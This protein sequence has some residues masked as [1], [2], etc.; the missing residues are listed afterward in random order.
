[1]RFAYT[2]LAAAVAFAPTVLG[3]AA[4]ATS[5]NTAKTIVRSDVTRGSTTACPA[6]KGPAGTPAVITNGAV[7]LT[8]VNF[9]GGTDGGLDFKAAL[10][11][12]GPTGT[13]KAV[14]V[15]TNGPAN[16]PAV[17]SAS[18]V[19]QIPAGTDCSKGNCQLALDSNG[20][21]GNCVAISGT[22]GNVAAAAG[23]GAAAATTTTAAA[24][25]AATGKKHHHHKSHK[26]AATAAPAAAAK[27]GK[28]AKKAR[29]HARDFTGSDVE[30][31][32]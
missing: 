19:V 14:T 29:E 24:A 21:F 17:T 16:P 13:F 7:T 32:E 15:T 4:I 9:N 8:G 2:L 22:S 30:L 27:K 5:A 25:A 12:T 11:T 10:S 28:N 3:H 20:G 6:F 23:A 26:A 18:L 1:M 31:M